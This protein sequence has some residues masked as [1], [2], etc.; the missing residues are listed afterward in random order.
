[1][2]SLSFVP[3]RTMQLHINSYERNIFDQKNKGRGMLENYKGIPLTT[4]F[5]FFFFLEHRQS[6]SNKEKH[7]YKIPDKVTIKLFILILLFNPITPRINREE[8][9]KCRQSVIMFMLKFHSYILNINYQF[10]QYECNYS[11][12]RKQIAVYKNSCLL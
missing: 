8:K 1:M 12:M 7:C 4:S 10:R 6:I 11:K 3:C 5:F 2:R 9:I